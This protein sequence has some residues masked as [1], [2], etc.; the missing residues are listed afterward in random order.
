MKKRKT[1]DVTD[2][3]FD[4]PDGAVVDGYERVGDRWV[5]VTARN[6]ED[7]SRIR[8]QCV[9]V[10]VTQDGREVRTGG[11]Q[12]RPTVSVDD[13]EFKLPEQEPPGWADP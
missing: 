9:S 3:D 1:F 6:D 4:A 13:R 2:P 5:P 8:E 7:V 12:R 11:R 10:A